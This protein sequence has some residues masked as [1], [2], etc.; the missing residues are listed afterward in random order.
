MLLTTSDLL[1][2]TFT[3]DFLP[4]ITLLFFSLYYYKNFNVIVISTVLF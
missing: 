4:S 2:V 3:P 1:S